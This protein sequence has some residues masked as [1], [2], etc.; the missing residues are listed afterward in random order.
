[1]SYLDESVTQLTI[2]EGSIPWMYLDSVG[3]VTV[4]VGDMLP[5]AAS[6]QALAFVDNT[7]QTAAAAAIV[8]DF[9]RVAAMASD[10]GSRAYLT[11]ASLQLPPGRIAS[12]LM[13]TVLKFDNSLRA[14]FAAYDT[15]PDTAKLGLLDMVFNLGP[16]GLFNGFPTFMGY[17]RNTDW[18]N[19]ATEC[20]RRGI[21]AARNAWTVEQFTQAATLQP[22]TV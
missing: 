3:N 6:A 1:M 11:A 14:E 5:D 8:T 17:A 20:N 9:Q 2:F 18:A 16:A 13:T 10:M 22:P 19:A 7:G 21:S 4:G 15:F 12:L